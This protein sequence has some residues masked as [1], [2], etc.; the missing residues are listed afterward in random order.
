MTRRPSSTHRLA[1]AAR[2]AVFALAAI[3]SWLALPAPTAASPAVSARPAVASG[4]A[5]IP[6]HFLRRWDPVTIFFSRDI[7]P[8]QGGAEDNP[9][10]FVTFSPAH[11]GAFTWLDGHTLQFKPAEPWPALA[12]FTWKVE[13][14]TFTL[15]TLMSTPSS[16]TPADGSDGLPQV[17]EITLVFPEALDAAALARMT[18]IDL[19]PL[20][21]VGG[22]AARVLTQADFTVK[23]VERPSRSGPATY[24]LTLREA[25]ALGL[26]ATVR[27][28]LAL[29]DDASAS[30]REIS[31]STAEPFRVV[32]VGCR[33]KQLPVTPEGSRYTRE[34]A[35]DCGTAQREVVVEFSATPAAIGPVEARNLVRFTP[36]VDKLT[37]S[38][39]GRTLAVAGDF[40]RDTL[41][42]V[43]L[44][45]T[46]LSDQQGRSLDL[47]AASEV[48][49]HFPRQAPYVLWGASQGIVERLGPQMVP[50]T[51]R[52]QERIDL[53]IH[54][55]DPL[56]RAFWPF[57]DT[58]V[59]LDE[60]QRPPGPGE[61]LKP[62]SATDPPPGSD[63][64]A[65]RIHALG[66]PSV[67][68]LLTIP[69]RRE[70][71]AASFG[72][73]L[74][75]H[76]ARIAGREQPGTYLVGLRDLAG[77]A[78]RHWL[79]LQVT[80]LSLSTIEEPHATRFVVTSLATGLPVVGANVRVEGVERVR[81]EE[82]QWVSFAKGATDSEGAFLWPAPGRANDR[83]RQVRRIVVER[84]G[85][86]L[87]LDP[88]RP[89]EVYADNQW[90][91]DHTTWLQWAIEPLSQRGPQ[92]ETLCHLFTERPVY[93]PE[94]DVH[95]KGYLR[96]RERGHLTPVTTS[97]W[98]VVD[99]P[100][101]LRWSYPL[102]LTAAGSFY[103]KFHEK[104]VPTG[105]YRVHFET[106]DRTGRYGRVSFQIEAYRVPRFEVRLHGP[107]AATLDQAFDVALTASYYAGG[108]VSGQPVQWRV[109]QFP[110]AWEPKK[111]EGFVYSSDARFSR[112]DRFEST[113]AVTKTDTTNESGDAR[114]RL[115]PTIESTASPRSYVVEATVTGPDDQT[116][117]ATR[118]FPALPPFVLGIKAPRFV[119]RVRQIVPELI[120]VGRD[121]ELIAGKEVTLRLLRREWHST[122]RASDFSDGMAHYLTDVVD[123]PVV[124]KKLSSL[125]QPLA[126]PLPIDRAGV[127]VVEIEAR[128]RLDRA[129]TV[130]VDLYAG[131]EGAITWPKPVAQ[132]ASVA[133]DRP[134]YDPGMTAAIVLKSPFQTAHALAI[135]EAPEGN[136]YQWVAI[137][138]GAATFKL[139]I[140]GTFTPRV[141]VHFVLMR[142]RL[143][144]TAPQPGNTTDL[145]KPATLAA[146]VWLDVNPVA[147][148][149]Q[150]ALNHPETARPGQR[151][152]VT[153]TL[154]DPQ[155][156][157]VAGEVTLWL[158]DQ[159]VLA[160]G[161]EQRLDPLP[162]FIT[163]VR[164]HLT[165]HDTRNLA[166]GVLPFAEHPGGDEGK[167]GTGLLDRVTVRKNFKSVPYFNPAIEVGPD[168]RVV[169]SVQLPDDLTNFMLRA[170]AA[171]GPERFGYATGRLAVRLP[172]I[173][174]PALPR[175]VRPGDRFTAT[176]I[177]RVV[178]G[179]GGAGAAEIRADGVKI[180][181][182]PR[183]NLTWVTNRPERV[184]FPVEVIT[185]PYTAEGRLSRTQVTFKMAV[186]RTSDAARDAFEATLPIRE[187]R[188]RVRVRLLKDLVP[189]TSLSI[190]ALTDRPRTGTLKRAVLVSN[191]PALIRMAAGLD[192][193]MGYPY[194]CTEQQVS[195]AR[196]YVALKKFR[197]VLHQEGTEEQTAHAMRTTLEW[198][199]TVVDGNG[200]VAYW[201]GASGNVALTAWTTQFLL[202][203]RAAGVAFDPAL[204]DR[205]LRALDQAL[206]SDYSHFIDGEAYLERAWALA[207]LA[208][209]GR[210]N[211]AYAAELARKA[212]YLDL[213]GVA[214]VVQAFAQ[215]KQG[216]EAV[217]QLSRALWDGI[218]VRLHQGHEIYGGLQDRP[219]TRNPL[220]LPTETRTLAEVT[221][222]LARVQPKHARLPVLTQ[223]LVTLGRD[224]GWGTTNAN[225]AA[226]LALSELLSPSFSG[227]A[228]QHLRLTF[229]GKEQA[230]ALGPNTPLVQALAS[231]GAEGQLVLDPG[232]SDNVVARVETSFVPE[233]DGS[234]VKAQSSGFVVARELLRIASAGAP[235]ERIAL[236]SAGTTQTFPVGQVVEDHVQVVNP[237][238]R[239]YV[240]IV[241]PLAAGMEPLNPHLATA[242]PEARPAGGITREPTYVA[243]LDDQ[244]AFYY[245]TL[246]AGTYDFYFRTRATTPGSFIQ[247]AAKA[248]MMYDG[249][250][251]GNS[252]GARVAIAPALAP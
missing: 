109:T 87:V 30:A 164:S 131:G 51:G 54:R 114:L 39:T 67:S 203:A 178:E 74:A 36:A 29:D 215:A 240:A 190:P 90:N 156:R 55:V 199:P 86:T 195:R 241:V 118:S 233:A 236:T 120:V 225:A 106:Q 211:P 38:V 89:P 185:P 13:A 239:H 183:R 69:L 34:Q 80:D 98:L 221:R 15:S 146:T 113:A 197:A 168:G 128:D 66:S 209:A 3:A 216:G 96:D 213:E 107:D 75:P 60:S 73:D 238:E 7:G 160:L 135:V 188:D 102:T 155:G 182:A 227:G 219:R 92:R 218:V 97:G 85:D 105:T 187:D 124:E 63:L 18:T 237:K 48:F 25:L 64:I 100:G 6:D 162:D 191:Q 206:R 189:G 27:L 223:A 210:F 95:I 251:V 91:R 144:G 193:L 249:S 20:P 8:Q 57:P 177:G 166:F 242:P 154:K 115:D 232:G 186:E 72:L 151:V 122:L 176:A 196:T 46:S 158:V 181:G 116:V 76:L 140:L 49:I 61:E 26:R 192:F 9:Q 99:G 56:D 149:L 142:G 180:D 88:S 2:R 161:K 41:Y 119:E 42:A 133:T 82:T 77:D 200:L 33:S 173:V 246:P 228:P 243:Y 4:T 184:E 31:F 117:T 163:A 230:L 205:L 68:A 252:N 138:G 165:A 126:V 21:G 217:D 121:G 201:P 108:K 231:T 35:I 84:A 58:A 157:P 159:A 17:S 101:D 62:T 81:G 40:A 214:E 194:G 134:R 222:A 19:R 94:E 93:R 50:V 170:K 244:V 169:V 245:N 247:P 207:A 110:Y 139:P 23:A 16:S 12:R 132:I 229:E 79:R 103:H 226:L 71:G 43:R 127:Y 220:I 123:Q 53:R 248:E 150:V 179:A 137:Q 22:G 147:N 111:R 172:V 5:V 145:G 171:S 148:Q 129:Q 83:W 136:R 37:F 47:R 104:D 78:T 141:P 143:P 202:E 153:I 174:Q 112:N 234:Q 1:P 250:V 212:E 224:D 45:A 198:L 44:A 10:R 52:G 125:A 235:P 208:Q 32:S 152:D 70:G 65:R 59:P 204:L 130:R 24:V 28:R 11:P 167:E 14:K 175:F